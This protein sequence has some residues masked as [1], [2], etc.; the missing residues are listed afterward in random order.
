[1]SF[2]GYFVSRVDLFMISLLGTP[3][4]V[5]IH[6]VAFRIAEQGMALRN[7]TEAAFFPIFIKRFQRGQIERRRLIAVS[8]L[9]LVGI[10]AAAF[11]C[12]LFVEDFVPMVFEAEYQASAHILSVL[13]FYVA[14]GWA[15]MPFS[16]AAQAT[17]NEKYLL[18]ITS[19]MAVSNVVLNYI[20]F[21]KFGLI[22]IAYSTL[23][24]FC[25]NVISLLDYLS[26]IETAGAFHMNTWCHHPLG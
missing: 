1:M 26:S 3:S 11:L 2:L 23:V 12:S 7:L 8:L 5:G 10:F 14:L 21:L 25:G 17:H 16:M 20:F 24:V 22:G 6:G 19:A 18:I 9:F 13:I 4:D 15:A